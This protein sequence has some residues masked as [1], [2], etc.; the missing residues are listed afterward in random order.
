M[1][2]NIELK[3]YFLNKKNYIIFNHKKIITSNILNIK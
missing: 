2:I 1:S 3:D